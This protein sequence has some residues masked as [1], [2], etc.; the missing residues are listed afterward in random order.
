MPIL[1]NIER[2]AME[3][4]YE[5]GRREGYEQGRQEGRQEGILFSA[6]E[7]LLIVLRARFNAVSAELSARVHNMTDVSTLHYLFKRAIFIPSLAEFEQVIE[8]NCRE[9]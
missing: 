9:D 6:R 5:Q 4:G 2:R 1:S 7:V 8:S 3:A